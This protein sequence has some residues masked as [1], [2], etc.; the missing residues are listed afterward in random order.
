MCVCTGDYHSPKLVDYLPI[1][2]HKPYNN[3][4]KCSKSVETCL[5]SYLRTHLLLYNVCA[6]TEGNGNAHLGEAAQMQSRGLVDSLHLSRQLW[7]R[8]YCI[9]S[10]SPKPALLGCVIGAKLS[11]AGS[12]SHFK[13][14]TLLVHLV[15]Y[16]LTI[17]NICMMIW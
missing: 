5:L 9:C 11:C 2:T 8:R 7:S 14:K 4:H 17:R 3:L 1:Q 6:S 13:R 16:L 12:L 10:A 15:E